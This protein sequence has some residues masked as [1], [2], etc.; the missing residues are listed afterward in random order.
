MNKLS[1]KLV[2]SAVCA[3]S[4]G[5]ADAGSFTGPGDCRAVWDETCLTVGN[6]LFSRRWRLDGSV[7]RTVS[8]GLSGAKN[9]FVAGE[10][11]GRA[12]SGLKVSC[13][14]D[15]DSAV[16]KASLLVS[17]EAGGRTMHVRLFPSVP[18]VVIFKE[19]N[20]DV[21]PA[22]SAKDYVAANRDASWGLQQCFQEQQIISDEMFN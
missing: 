16:S 8:F 14:V 10:V 17:A 15:R 18:G 2:L 21:S 6:D 19:W 12:Q 13:R 1:R 9:P 7:L 4:S 3:L 20:D 11:R 22:P 5:V